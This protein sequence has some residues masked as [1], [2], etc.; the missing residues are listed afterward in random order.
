MFTYMFPKLETISPFLFSDPDLDLRDPEVNSAVREMVF[1]DIDFAFK[2]ILNLPDYID[3]H[4]EWYR[5]ER[6]NRRT[7]LLGPR[8]S[9]KCLSPDSIVATP[10]GFMY[11][12]NTYDRAVFSYFFNT[13]AH[14]EG[15][16]STS[17]YDKIVAIHLGDPLDFFIFCSPDHVFPVFDISTCSMH[18][19]RARFLIPGIHYLLCVIPHN[20]SYIDTD[21][22][23][24]YSDAIVPDCLNLPPDSFDQFFRETYSKFESLYTRNQ[25]SILRFMKGLVDPDRIADLKKE[26][27]AKMQAVYKDPTDLDE[28][29]WL[30][31]LPSNICTAL[32]ATR[33]GPFVFA[34]ISK[35][36]K[37]NN[38]F[39]F[40]VD[41][42]TSTG[43]FVGNGAITHNSTVTTVFGSLMAALRDPNLRIAIISFNSKLSTKCVSRIRSICE[44]NPVIRYVFPDIINPREIKLW[45][46]EALEFC[47]STLLPE[48]TIWALSVGTDFTGL[49]FDI[50]H[51]DD[52]VTLQ[53]RFSPA[54]RT[55]T[56][57]W[58]RLTALPALESTGSAHVKGTRYHWDDLYG[59]LYSLF[60]K[61]SQWKV[62]RT[63]AADE[64]LYAQGII[65]SFWPEKFSNEELLHIKTEIGDDAFL[66]QYQVVAGKVVD[67]EMVD[68]HE[69][70][71]AVFLDEDEIEYCRDFVVAADLAAPRSKVKAYRKSS[72]AIVV[73][74]R[75]SK[76]QKWVV[77]DTFK[78]LR[79]PF[80]DQRNWLIRKCQEF[81]PAW[82]VT[83]HFAYQSVFSEYIAAHPDWV[84]PIRTAPGADSK[85]FKFDA[86]VLSLTNQQLYLIRG[87]TDAFVQEIFSYPETSADLIDGVYNALRTVPRREPSIRTL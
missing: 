22:Q 42:Q 74:G 5:F 17:A 6:D 54:I 73:L 83:E 16:G 72:F 61:D 24:S 71:S 55:R 1:T 52:L 34:P 20:Q 39:P 8:G 76:L 68:L 51:F 10:D 70:I 21:P 44:R 46:T 32:D 38:P 4:K 69:R 80:E 9:Y 86:V 67:Q 36:R 81:N 28:L 35:T 79:V 49:H 77:V 41:I 56:W 66:L 7:L 78:K 58:F 13:T 43:F 19:V 65:E 75:H 15:I 82:V 26:T 85:D 23:V 37:L 27:L 30:L 2:A 63:P 59:R 14:V 25:L 33:E 64:D 57:D 18:E 45:S 29:R 47:R 87:R 60:E 62:K 3:V 12:A 84:W 53:H 11:I 31:G 40:L 48:P 50:V